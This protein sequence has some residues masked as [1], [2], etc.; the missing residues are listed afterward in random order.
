MTEIRQYRPTDRDDVY[1]ICTL[2]GDSGND[3]TGHFRS[4]DLLPD[5]YAGPYLVHDPELVRLVDAGDGAIG[6]VL[7]T[8]DSVAFDRWFV[9]TWWP[10]VAD[11]HPLEGAGERE[12]SIIASAAAREQLPAEILERYPAHLHID[13]L[14]VTQGQ[15]LG[16]RLIETF[17]ELLAARGVRGVHLGV[18]KRNVGAHRFYE[19]TGFTRVGDP[20]GPMLYAKEL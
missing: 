18:D 13:L 11:E 3:A 15:G 20:D 12:A 1:R 9:D 17:T 6:Y 14:P 2:T 5:I 19:R 4:D 7:G 10:S 16:R 8:T